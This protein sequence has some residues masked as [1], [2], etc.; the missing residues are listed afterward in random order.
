MTKT[1][2]L[3]GVPADLG[4]NRRGVS[5]GPQAA[6]FAGLS[7]TLTAL[8]VEVA[9]WGN[10]IVG[11]G[12]AEEGTP[13]MKHIEAI[14]TMNETLAQ[15]VKRA[16]AQSLIPLVIGGDHSLSIGSI[17]G[18]AM[19]RDNMGIIWF[20]AHGDYNSPET[21]PSGN[22]HGMSLAVSHGVGDPRLVN[23]GAPGPKIAEKNTVLVG[24]RD[25]DALEKKRLRSTEM[26]I[27]TMKD[28]D[29][30]GMKE[31]VSRSVQIAGQG[32][33]GIHVSFD[34]D[35]LDPA[36][37]PGVSTPVP[38]GINYRE[39][40][41]AMEILADQDAFRSIDVVELNPLMDLQNKT[42][43][44]LVELLSSAFGKQII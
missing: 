43:R 28:I 7:D 12:G 5:L 2:A 44:L 30:L 21:T 3:I 32:G 31:I 27:F 17:A 19:Q 9:D 41:L 6:R 16:L 1:V 42:A 35:V 36:E 29:Q 25:L 20:D 40:H 14:A 37:A 38:G 15:M 34:L 13:S 23:C 4:A 11:D 39:A 24:V 10:L 22:I 26:T 8:G 33:G 18:A